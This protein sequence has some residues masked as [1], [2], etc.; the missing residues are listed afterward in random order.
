M[1]FLCVCE[2]LSACVFTSNVGVWPRDLSKRWGLWISRFL[3]QSLGFVAEL[4]CSLLPSE[5][6]R[7]KQRCNEM[8]QIGKEHDLRRRGTSASAR[9]DDQWSVVSRVI[10]MA[11]WSCFKMKSATEEKQSLLQGTL[12]QRVAGVILPPYRSWTKWTGSKPAGMRGSRAN[13]WSSFLSVS[14]FV[15]SIFLCSIF[16][17]L[18]FWGKRPGAEN[19]RG[20]TLC[21]GQTVVRM[22][23]SCRFNVCCDKQFLLDHHVFNE[24]SF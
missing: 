1:T 16:K 10:C 22:H 7:P 6:D 14:C 12:P 18:H 19:C 4:I 2:S 24:D 23:L 17:G 11:A 5:A 15:T 9:E 21:S 13:D 8:K 3:P 20:W